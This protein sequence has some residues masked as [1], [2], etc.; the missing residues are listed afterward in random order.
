MRACLTRCTT[1]MGLTSRLNPGR[2]FRCRTRW[3][4]NVP[5]VGLGSN[6]F[7]HV[8][9]NCSG[10]AATASTHALRSQL[11][12]SASHLSSGAHT[13]AAPPPHGQHTHARTHA[14]TH[15]R[16]AKT[17][18]ICCRCLPSSSGRR[19]TASCGWLARFAC[20]SMTRRLQRWVGAW[21]A[22]AR[23]GTG[24]ILPLPAS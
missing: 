24:S 12:A 4:G 11:C 13:A 7:P 2:A 16:T 1:Q 9:I 6:R 18:L 3:A 5:A 17:R 8:H 20:W 15:E 14:R 22:G 10:A 21:R 23:H 19:R